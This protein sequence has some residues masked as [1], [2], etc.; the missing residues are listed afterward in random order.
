MY[1]PTPLL[2]Q[3]QFT[4]TMPKQLHLE[5]N[6]CNPAPFYLHHEDHSVERD[7]DEHCVLKG[8][9][10]HEMPQS[11]LEGLPVLGHVAG[12]RLGA[13]GEV[14]TGSLV[15]GGKSQEQD[16]RRTAASRVFSH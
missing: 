14:N 7:H 5:V 2:L 9:R 1:S 8:G 15:G 6:D 4:V 3:W 13:D 12:H 16:L 10:G 11:I